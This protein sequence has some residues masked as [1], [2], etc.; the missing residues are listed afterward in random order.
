MKLRT[1][2]ALGAA[3]AVLLALA[4]APTASADWHSCPNWDIQ[5]SQATL[6]QSVVATVS[7]WPPSSATP[8]RSKSEKRKAKSVQ[9]ARPRATSLQIPRERKVRH[10]RTGLWQEGGELWNM[11]SDADDEEA[12][13]RGLLFP[14]EHALRAQA[15]RALP[16]LPCGRA[17]PGTGAP[18]GLRLP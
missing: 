15:R 16:D 5:P 9:F 4:A 13:L 8:S 6:T 11:V 3:C 12:E 10:L 14:S 1:R 2:A 18:A 7:S 17:R